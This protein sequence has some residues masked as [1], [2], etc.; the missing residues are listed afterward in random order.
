MYYLLMDCRDD[1][2]IHKYHK[3]DRK[4][5]PIGYVNNEICVCITYGSYSL[6]WTGVLGTLRAVS[7]RRVDI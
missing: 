6:A 7:L 3:Q 1:I 2:N 4:C 5:C